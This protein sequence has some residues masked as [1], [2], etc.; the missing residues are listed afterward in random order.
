MAQR[1]FGKVVWITG[2]GSG[3]GKAMAL[4]FARQG[5]KLVLSGRRVERLEEVAD[6]IK[7]QGGEA[8]AVA[9]DVADDESLKAAAH[10]ACTHWGRLDVA[11]ANAGFGIQS[12]IEKLSFDEW[13]RQ[14]DTNVIGL[15]LTARYALPALRGAKGRLALVGSVMAMVPTP[16]V[17]AYT[18]SKYAVRAIGQTLAMECAKDGV[19]CTT[20]HPGFVESEIGQIDRQ[21]KF[22]ANIRDQRPKHL[23]WTSERAAKVMVR[24]IHRRKREY[25]FTIHG[26]LAGFIGRHMPWLLHWALKLR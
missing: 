7:A 6:A 15:A 2:A 22:D 17:G 4:E 11:V 3:L 9:C 24:A 25:V 1:F 13:R 12:S 21:G 14:L 16:K 10:T 5:A 20:L 8:L 23:M 19:S 18:A 26:K